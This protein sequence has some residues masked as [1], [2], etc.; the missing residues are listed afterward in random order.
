M[1]RANN[2]FRKIFLA[3][4][5][6][7]VWLFSLSYI[8]WYLFNFPVEN[9]ENANIVY[10]QQ[11][12]L[13]NESLANSEVI[14]PDQLEIIEYDDNPVENIEVISEEV[15][16]EETHSAPIVN[17]N[18]YIPY[19]VITV[20]KNEVEDS[21]SEPEE[22]T[23]E[24][25]VEVGD[26]FVQ[27]SEEKSQEIIRV[28]DEPIMFEPLV[29]EMFEDDLFLPPVTPVY[30][31]DF[32]ADFF[33]SGSDSLLIEDGVYYYKLYID[34]DY[35]SDIEVVFENGIMSFQSFE[36]KLYVG[37]LITEKAYE[38]IFNNAPE[39]INL[40][41]LEE[42]G[43]ESV[44]DDNNFTIKLHFSLI[45]MPERVLSITN[46]S[47]GRD[48]FSLSGATEIKKNF[49]SLAT[50]FS[51][52]ANYDWMIKPKYD[53]WYLS[54]NSSNYMTF[55][56][57]NLDLY[58]NIGYRAD[59]LSL[60]VNSYRFFYDFVDQSIRVSFG[61]VSGYGLGN[62]NTSV[63][64]QFEKN[65]S[66][67]NQSAKRNSQ[68]QYVE[69]Y[70]DSRIS[71]ESNGKKVYERT[72]TPGK[73]RVK[74][75]SFETGINEV[76]IT[77]TPL[78]V[79]SAYTD[80]EQIK[81][82]SEIYEFS[83]AYDSQ[84][85]SY[86][87]CLYG[88]SLTIGRETIRSSNTTTDGL[89]LKILPDYY[90]SYHFNDIALSWYQ[91]FGISDTIT[92]NSNYSV[93]ATPNGNNA[94]SVNFTLINANRLGTSTFAFA[95]KIDSGSNIPLLGLSL[96]HRFI[97]KNKIV[98]SLSFAIDYSNPVTNGLV[99]HEFS[100]SLNFG[101]S[102]GILRYSLSTLLTLNSGSILDPIWR[103][104]GSLSFSPMKNM[105]IST[106]VSAYQ[107]SS[108]SDKPQIV[109]YISASYSFGKTNISYSSDYFKNNNIN[110]SSSIGNDN[111]N[112]NVSRLDFSDFSKHNLASSYTHAGE[113]YLFGIRAQ[114]YDNYNRF[115]ASMNLSTAVFYTDGM[116]AIS[117][118]VKDNFLIIRPSGSIKK[119][120]IEVAKSTGS[121]AVQLK[122]FFGN[123]MYNGL[124]SRG[125][126]N[127]VVYVSGK[128]EF[129]DTQTFAYELNT[130]GRGGFSIR[131]KVPDVF[132]VSA[133]IKENGV[134]R[135]DFSSPV[136]ELLTDSETGIS[137]LA[138]NP[139]LYLFSD[140]DG[141]FLISGVES[142]IYFFD[143]NYENAWYAVCF[144]V[145]EDKNEDNRVWTFD[146][147][148]AALLNR[149]D[150]NEDG[151]IV[152][153]YD[154]PGIELL[155]EYSGYAVLDNGK[156][157]NTQDFWN[158]LFP[159]FDEDMD[160]FSTED[161]EMI[162]DVVVYSAD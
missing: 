60:N 95:S 85:L 145:G 51:F 81:E 73:Y 131:A 162:S 152:G 89:L 96:N 99:D 74:D 108:V 112:L 124:S 24:E 90:H 121:N 75:F 42:K 53:Y 111:V 17:E 46:Y 120:T 63:G 71:V 154:V 144:I 13:K 72:V 129:A 100:L 104:N 102:L 128:N 149:F 49:F 156:A 93:K 132:T 30:D 77:I 50:A 37:E 136:Y 140:Q 155:T 148:D 118:S 141:R 3:V 84:L 2:S 35:L 29:M 92:L 8:I 47:T 38:R 65:Y 114:S 151:E 27:E 133:V 161:E 28:P 9:K 69:V 48:R 57:L 19:N 34:E 70:E 122:T 21:S 66:F 20:F 52:Y 97:M 91:N 76:A 25:I 36:L 103:I 41:Y 39:M 142:G 126:N 4:F 32:F 14:L 123:G 22:T 130:K 98:S 44:C 117:R 82:H 116:F 59:K 159:A 86:G 139:N 54:L 143:Y 6:S 62:E 137:R 135:S 88:G 83:L 11:E 45:D 78:W 1:H 127:L 68:Q 147:F 5:F 110:F 23:Q 134:P 64:I 146:D 43:V 109:G 61:N 58:Y 80:P 107:N 33:V 56:D 105:S 106:S 119:A 160:F 101:G 79:L 7:L 10:Q 115:S 150:H 113:T 94:A 12:D 40:E 157:E 15:N 16:K 26:V 18:P 153:S 125:R 31:D 87:D 158:N 67:G 55:G 138:E